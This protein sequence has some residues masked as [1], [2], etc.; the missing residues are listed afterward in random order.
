MNNQ[1]ILMIVILIIGITSSFGMAGYGLRRR[2]MPGSIFFVLLALSI[3]EWSL[4]YLYELLHPL[5]AQKWLLFQIKY[6]GAAFLTLFLLVFVLHFV[7]KASWLRSYVWPVLLVKPILTLSLV[8]IPAFQSLFVTN[9]QL[10]TAGPF[11]VLTFH[12]EIGFQLT[13]IYDLLITLF[14][15]GLLFQHS[16][17][18][19]GGSRKQH[20]I[21]I[22]GALWAWFGGVTSFLGVPLLANIDIIPILLSAVLPFLAFGAFHYRL[23][24]LIPIARDFVL[25]SMDD[26]ILVLDPQGRILDINP[27]GQKILNAGDADITGRLVEEIL[28]PWPLLMRV[29]TEPQTKQAEVE[30]DKPGIQR[31]YEVRKSPLLAGTWRR[32][33]LLIILR[34]ITERS[35]LETA[36]RQSE[37]K[38]RSVVERGNDGIAILQN[39]KIRY[40]NPQLAHL[41]GR[42]A[43]QTIGLDFTEILPETLRDMIFTRYLHRLDGQLEPERYETYLLKANGEQVDVEI[44]AGLIDYE[45]QP[46]VLTFAHD[47]VQRKQNMQLV[48]ESEER[49]RRI[50]ELISDFAYACRV[51]ADGKMASIW[52]TGAFTRI[53]GVPLDQTDP[54]NA[55]ISRILV[56]DSY[57]ALRHVERLMEGKPDVAEFR[58]LDKDGEMRWIRDYVRPIWD[59]NEGRVTWFYGASQEITERKRMEESLREA[60]ETAEAATLAKSQF[61]ANMSHEIRTP[62]NAIIGMTSLLVETELDEEQRDFVETIRT[63]GDALLT[64]INDIL[65]FS[66]IEAGKLELEIQPFN[67]YDCLEEAIDIIAPHA[68]GKS[69][70]LIYEIDQSVPRSIVGDVARLRQVLVNLIGNAVKFTEQGEILVHAVGS[71][72]LNE[73]GQWCEIHFLVQDTGIGIPTDRLDRLFHSFSQ[74]DA[75]TTRKYGGTGLGLAITSRL[76][77]LMGGRIWVESSGGAGID[78]PCSG[79][80]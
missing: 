36:L 78:L 72:L 73:G 23:L 79:S 52:A 17:Q 44:T 60:K 10:T 74:I 69:L 24:D 45:G 50:S 65:D 71:P 49:Y 70:D 7:G 53:T 33:G 38:Y 57:V 31:L 27:A 13:G 34:D 22:F 35:R 1:L 30:I 3:A 67:V 47:I 61:L 80:L 11:P 55:L 42:T 46:A 41:L 18:T 28:A 9:L 16:L 37:L 8:W 40:C 59:D 77:E 29:V 39:R 62:L 48:H 51:D 54:F 19:S 66:K 76:V 58:I 12:K 68:S 6:F 32:K 21:L 64:V 14:V 5:L 25:E 26:G 75:S 2:V 20:L 4:V 63:S 43:D 56:E 15:V